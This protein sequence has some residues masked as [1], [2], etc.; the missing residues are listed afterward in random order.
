MRAVRA[1]PARGTYLGVGVADVDANRVGAL[2][3]KEARGA[4]VTMVSQ[5]GPAAKAGIHVGDVI[6]EYNGQRVEGTAELQR[7]VR[8]TPAGHQAKIALWRS[9]ASVTITATIEENDHPLALHNDSWPFG[10]DFP[11]MPP[12]PAID[13]PRMVTTYENSA[14]GVDCQMLSPNSQFADFLG[15]K[16]GLL[17]MSVNRNSAAEKAGIKA[18]DVIVKAGDAHIANH[19]ELSGAL[20]ANRGKT[21]PLTVMRNKHETVLTVTL[22]ENGR[23]EHF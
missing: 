4:E 7:L 19:R 12:M 18:G 13:I 9:G 21:T 15:V 22:D 2:K 10:P 20:R 3:L 17:V 23:P 14:L 11:N 5:D 8:E 16:D 1:M 6:L